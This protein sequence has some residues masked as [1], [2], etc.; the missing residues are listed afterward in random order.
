MVV[1]RLRNLVRR[2][3]HVGV[4]GRQGPYERAARRRLHLDRGRRGPPLPG[5]TQLRIRR[6]SLVH[7]RGRA[8][9]LLRCKRPQGS[10]EVGH[11]GESLGR[12]EAHGPQDDGLEL[13][14]KRRLQGA[15]GPRRT[16]GDGLQHGVEAVAIEGALARQAL[17]GDHAERI[18]IARRPRRAAAHDLL[19]GEVAGGPD[20]GA[21]LGPIG[22][23]HDRDPEVEDLGLRRLRLLRPLARREEDVL[24]LEVAVG[25]ACLMRSRDRVAEGKQ[26]IHRLV[27][28]DR[29]RTFE[30]LREILTAQQLHH[31]IGVFA[32]VDRLGH[33]D[34]VGVAHAD[35]DLRLAQ[36][37]FAGLGHRG[38][39]ATEDLHRHALTGV[40]R[41]LVNRPHGAGADEA[42]DAILAEHRARAD[43]ADAVLVPPLTH[44][45]LHPADPTRF[46]VR[47]PTRTEAPTQ[48]SLSTVAPTR[49]VSSTRKTRS[50]KTPHV[51]EYSRALGGGSHRR[52]EAAPGR[53]PAAGAHGAGART[54][55]IP[56]AM[57]RDSAV[58]S[59][60]CGDAPWRWRGDRAAR[61]SRRRSPAPRATAVWARGRKASRRRAGRARPSASNRRSARCSPPAGGLL[62][63][64]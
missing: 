30:P 53:R 51:T 62:P 61:R 28:R 11:R 59:G 12:L 33:V 45:L 5:R 34:D 23:L 7:G 31:Q 41:A 39:A 55:R 36:K 20:E 14:G 17:V 4:L 63:P 35:R 1:E 24:R 29:P 13:G 44:V 64:A 60:T 2:R 40:V 48:T 37:S 43:R 25:D 10:P 38:E 46:F 49:L 9:G 56:G 57:S 22:P 27:R 3:R 26:D 19:G 16:R 18:L 47:S 58:V 54:D 15:G 8:I 52:A 42:Y 50:E 21:A 32:F 6:P